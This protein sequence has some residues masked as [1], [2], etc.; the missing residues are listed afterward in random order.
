MFLGVSSPSRSGPIDVTAF[1]LWAMEEDRRRN[2]DYLAYKLATCNIGPEHVAL[3]QNEWQQVHEEA[4]RI[5]E[6][7]FNGECMGF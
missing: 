2:L 6:E 5:R 7:W 1:N 3:T 4:Q